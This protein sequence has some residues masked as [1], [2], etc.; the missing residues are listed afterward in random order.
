MTDAQQPEDALSELLRFVLDK[1]NVKINKEQTVT[2]SG[3]IFIADI[4]RKAKEI[5][6]RPHTLAPDDEMEI[7]FTSKRQA[8]EQG[9]QDGGSAVQHDLNLI[10][11][12]A[13]RT[14]TLAAYEDLLC[15]INPDSP[16]GKHIARMKESLRQQAGEQ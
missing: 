1:A 4:V 2:I 14:A 6:S 11:D 12:K 16:A 13:A 15:Y 5:R 8:W 9:Y 7:R 3:T 10:E